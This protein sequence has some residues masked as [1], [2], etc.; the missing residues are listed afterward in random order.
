M[1]SLTLEHV[2]HAVKQTP[3]PKLKERVYSDATAVAQLV[4]ALSTPYPDIS[5]WGCTV[6]GFG[7][8]TLDKS[9]KPASN[10]VLD[11][12]LTEDAECSHN[13]SGIRLGDRILCEFGIVDESQWGQ[14]CKAHLVDL[15]ARKNLRC[16]Y[17]QKPDLDELAILCRPDAVSSQWT[18]QVLASIQAN[19]MTQATPPAPHSSGGPRL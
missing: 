16:T 8:E 9:K 11:S 17:T 4:Q 10:N 1:H 13:S 6:L 3:H 14:A 15:I 7:L 12:L 2:E 18:Q 5:L 19:L